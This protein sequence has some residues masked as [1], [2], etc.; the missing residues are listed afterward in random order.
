MD[1]AHLVQKVKQVKHLVDSMGA[2]FYASLVH[3]SR[4]ERRVLAF[5]LQN[6]VNE[7]LQEIL[8]LA[9]SLNFFSESSLGKKEGFGRTRRYVL[10]RRVSPYFNLDPSGFSGYFW[11]TSDFLNKAI[12]DPSKARDELK[13]RLSSIKDGAQM[14]LPM[15]DLSGKSEFLDIQEAAYEED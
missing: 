5:A 11:V 6:D 8:R 1:S 14:S 10:N 12:N 15:D 13:K 2:A 9:V 3:P 4:S 7:E